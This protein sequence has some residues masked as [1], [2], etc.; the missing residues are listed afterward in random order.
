MD[1]GTYYVMPSHLYIIC[2]LTIALCIGVTLSDS[3][4]NPNAVAPQKFWDQFLHGFYAS[5]YVIVISELGDKTFFIAAIMSMQ[6]SRCLVYSGAMGALATMTVLSAMLG[7]A[8]TV[9]PRK[10]TYYTSGVLFFIFGIKMLFDAYKMS[11]SDVQEEY[12]EVKQQLS[13]T[14]DPELG[15]LESSTP[16]S[17]F[18]TQV[19]VTIRRMFSPI[20]AEAFILT[21]LAEWGDRSQI[22]TIVMAATKV[23]HSVIEE[24]DLGLHSNLPANKRLWLRTVIIL[25]IVWTP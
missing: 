10:L 13:N 9:I 21:F 8:T 3:V 6:H 19:R 17:S 18:T 12:E 7:Y 11:P 1:L 15:K 2:C 22:T 16:D 25:L 23:S 14:V 20:L 4:A 5:L 24:R